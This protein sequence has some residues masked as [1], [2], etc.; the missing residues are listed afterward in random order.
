MPASDLG[1]ADQLAQQLRGQGLTVSMDGEIGNMGF[2]AVPAHQVLAA[3]QRI[4]V[5]QYS[6]PDKASADAALISPDG[7]PNPRAQIDWIS[8]P[9]FYRQ[10]FMIVLYVGCSSQILAALKATVGPPFITGGGVC[11]S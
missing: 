6:S 1:T 9:H 3:G 10:G 4:S 5:F 7:Q 2:F 11:P 8:V